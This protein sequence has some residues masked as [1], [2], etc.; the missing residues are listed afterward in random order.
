[1]QFKKTGMSM[2][3]FIESRAEAARQGDITLAEFTEA[4]QSGDRARMDE[5][6]ERMYDAGGYEN[7][8]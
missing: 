7:L 6:V 8:E 3:D 1:M 4:M 2:L 5:A